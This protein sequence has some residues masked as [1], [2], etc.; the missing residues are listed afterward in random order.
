MVFTLTIDISAN[1]Q[2]LV[3]ALTDGNTYTSQGYIAGQD[4]SYNELN[5]LSY[6]QDVVTNTTDVLYECRINE[7][8][9]LSNNFNGLESVFGDLT[10]KTTSSY[11]TLTAISY[12][13]IDGQLN[14]AYVFG[15]YIYTLGVG[16]TFKQAILEESQDASG[17]FT[18]YDVSNNS[19]GTVVYDKTNNRFTATNDIDPKYNYQNIS[20]LAN[21]AICKYY[22]DL[23]VSG[24]KDN[25]T[26]SEVNAMYAA[27]ASVF[28][29]Y[30]F[31]TPSAI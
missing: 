14:S 23:S 8:L 17:V 12:I 27:N 30:G 26:S 11:E 13:Q 19:Y 3:Y 24:S 10:N 25:Y 31:I 28:N 1:S 20:I 7:L 16:F 29:N 5:Y 22:K 18:L 6:T 15:N 9:D 2:G 21:C 4:S